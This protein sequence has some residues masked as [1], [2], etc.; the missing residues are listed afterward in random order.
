MPVV[1]EAVLD[2]YRRIR[3]AGADGKAESF[4]TT[5]RRVGMDPFKAAANG[6]RFVERET[7]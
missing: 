4:I 7:A 2:T 6:A 1:I 3:Q 5:L